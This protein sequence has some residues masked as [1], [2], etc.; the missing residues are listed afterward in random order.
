[1]LIKCYVIS[2]HLFGVFMLINLSYFKIPD[3][4]YNLKKMKNKNYKK[5]NKNKKINEKI[6]KRKR[7]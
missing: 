5:I 7:N 1:M 4:L 2:K 3:F 6:K